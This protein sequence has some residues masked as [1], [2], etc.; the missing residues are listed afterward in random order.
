MISPIGSFP[1]ITEIVRIDFSSYLRG[2]I[3]SLPFLHCPVKE[4]FFTMA[5]H[6]M[7]QLMKWEEL[8]TGRGRVA[9]NTEGNAKIN[10]G[11]LP[12]HIF[13]LT[14][15][16]YRMHIKPRK[17]YVPNGTTQ[18][19]SPACTFLRKTCTFLTDDEDMKCIR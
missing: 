6:G 19:T 14:L 12:K 8:T 13:T 10:E 15:L 5:Q 2:I 3:V 7:A 17:I 11:N 1:L 9:T 18:T 16:L 4:F